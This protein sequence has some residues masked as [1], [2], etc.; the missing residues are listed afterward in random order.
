MRSELHAS[1]NIHYVSGAKAIEQCLG[2][3]VYTR[4]RDVAGKASMPI[5]YVA[6]S[7]PTGTLAFIPARK[8]K[9]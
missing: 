8:E 2:Q 4:W 6:I 9:P 1:V 7:T 3:M 5:K